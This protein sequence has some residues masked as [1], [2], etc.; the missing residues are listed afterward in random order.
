MSCFVTSIIYLL[1]DGASGIVI[2][3]VISVIYF[4]LGFFLE[5]CQFMLVS[6]LFLLPMFLRAYLEDLI[7]HLI[8]TKDFGFGS[9]AS[10][11]DQETRIH[12]EFCDWLEI[13][14]NDII[15]NHGKFNY[16]KEYSDWLT[17]KKS[18]KKA[19]LTKQRIER[20]REE[21]AEKRAREEFIKDWISTHHQQC[22]KC[23]GRGYTTEETGTHQEWV[24]VQDGRQGEMDL[25]TVSDYS[26]IEC[27]YCHGTGLM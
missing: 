6:F 2:I 18:V 1:S 12:S 10:E 5:E 22:Y 14:Y 21:R 9:K 17:K 11:L 3:F 26:E 19:L 15:K 13:N 27:A 20:E 7:E 16:D 8:T 23:Y 25:R 4:I 24:P